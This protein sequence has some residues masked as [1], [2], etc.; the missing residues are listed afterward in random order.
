MSV[1]K[2]SWSIIDVYNRGDI[3]TS[4]RQRHLLMAARIISG[5]V[6]VLAESVGPLKH[7]ALTGERLPK[8][9]AARATPSSLLLPENQSASRRC[10]S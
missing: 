9:G 5:I 4:Y 7:C 8:A 10:I 1:P 6:K 2:L 3:I